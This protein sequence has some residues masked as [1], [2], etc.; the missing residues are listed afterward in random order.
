MILAVTGGR[1]YRLT[2]DDCLGIQSIIDKLGVT[3][4]RHG[5]CRGADRAVAAFV[6][7]AYP[8]V[9][10]EAYQATWAENGKAAG[11]IRNAAMLLGAHALLALPGGKG[12]ADAVAKA[13]ARGIPIHT[14]GASPAGESK[15]E[16]K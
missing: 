15:E 16:G 14:L 4:V 6:R 13:K 1:D 3:E 11:P 7:S 2:T 12:T 8:R 10:V 5:D 9:R